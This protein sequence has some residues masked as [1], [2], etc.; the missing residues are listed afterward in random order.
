MRTILSPH[1]IEQKLAAFDALLPEYIA[2][3]QFIQALQGQQR[4]DD[5]TIDTT[6]HYLHARW[7][8]E[9]KDRLL[10]TSGTRSAHEG[11]HCLVMLARWQTGDAADI[12]E[13]LQHHLDTESLG[14][15]SRQI[16]QVTRSSG[17]H[18]A[19]L[20]LEQGRRVMLNRNL[21]FLRLIDTIVATPAELMVQRVLEAS[22]RYGHA[23]AA[24]AHQL[25]AFETPL[26]GPARHFTLA[27]RNMLLMNEVGTTMIVRPVDRSGHRTW[28]VTLPTE[29]PGPFAQAVIPAYHTNS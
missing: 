16:Q 29:P 25:A 23:P 24:I 5:F 19:M 2:S 1:L 28:Q 7:V 17:D 27:Q 18:S 4:L 12:I 13:Y 26:Y 14:L 20:P 10:G 8:L 11:Q 9:C 6:V 15:L 22:E 3:F 21:H